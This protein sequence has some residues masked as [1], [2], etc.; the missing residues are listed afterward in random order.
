MSEAGTVNISSSLES[1]WTSGCWCNL[2]ACQQPKPAGWGHW[3]AWSIASWG[4]NTQLAKMLLEPAL[5]EAV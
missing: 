2:Q 4:Q 3:D 1:W 5:L